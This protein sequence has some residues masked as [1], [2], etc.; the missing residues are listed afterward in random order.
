MNYINIPF[1]QPK[2]GFVSEYNLETFSGLHPNTQ[3]IFSEYFLQRKDDDLECKPSEFLELYRFLDFSLL[4]ETP[5]F[6]RNLPVFR[7]FLYNNRND[8]ELTTNTIPIHKNPYYIF[9]SNTFESY[10]D[11]YCIQLGIKGDS[12]EEKY[13]LLG[14]DDISEYLR[15]KCKINGV[16]CKKEKVKLDINNTFQVNALITSNSSA[17]ENI[18]LLLKN[19][20][21]NRNDLSLHY[22]GIGHAHLGDIDR[23][24]KI[25]QLNWELNKNIISYRMI[26]RIDMFNRKKYVIE[27]IKKNWE[28][29]GD[30]GS[31]NDYASILWNRGRCKEAENLVI[32]NTSDSI[33]SYATMM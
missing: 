19:W 25:F 16:G 18:D 22:Y 5:E 9:K 14:Y 11:M 20:E 15:T 13:N 24:Y 28:E 32:K 3:K 29:N 33:V 2:K 10:F 21:E 8:L 23:A 6:K 27:D 12:Y 30:I 26:L 17:Y 1:F 4:T 31:M 7:R